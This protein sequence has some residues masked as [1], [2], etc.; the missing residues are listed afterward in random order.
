MKKENTSYRD[1]RLWYLL[2][3]S[4]NALY[5]A[6]EKE[7]SQYGITVIQSAILYL[8]TDCGGKATI[9][10]IARGMSKLPSV[11]SEQIEIMGKLGLI[12]EKEPQDKNKTSV[13]HLTKK[14]EKTFQEATKCESIH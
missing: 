11:I 3:H 13:F 2:H 9:A 14:G 4:T 10:D 7:L 8:I 6:R 12:E 5:L 1:F